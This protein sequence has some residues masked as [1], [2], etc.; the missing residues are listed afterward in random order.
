MNLEYNPDRY[1]DMNK[2]R[3]SRRELLQLSALTLGTMSFKPFQPPV[4]DYDIASMHLARVVLDQQIAI[5]KEPAFHS[6]IYRWTRQDE[7]LNIYY[8]LNSFCICS[9]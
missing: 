6:G 7:L 3:I 2:P 1:L 8:Q 4:D 9:L 5:Y